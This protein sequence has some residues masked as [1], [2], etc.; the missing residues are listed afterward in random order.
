MVLP[1]PPLRLPVVVLPPLAATPEDESV[2]V[3]SEACAALADISTS[4]ST[5]AAAT[6]AM[7]ALMNGLVVI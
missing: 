2:P 1:I 3:T 7:S 4:A 5:V 6:I